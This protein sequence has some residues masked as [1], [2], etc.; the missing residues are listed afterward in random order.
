MSLPLKSISQATPVA[1]GSLIGSSFQRT[2]AKS[3]FF[4]GIGVHSGHPVQMTIRPGSLNNGY[5][6]I[7]K[8]LIHKGFS[9]SDSTIIARWD[10]VV[11]TCMSTKISNTQGVS[12]STVEHV[13]AALYGC[14]VSNACIEINAEEVPILDGSSVEYT[15]A[16]LHAGIETQIHPALYKTITERVSVHGKDGSFIEIFPS[17]RR[18]M[19][20]ELLGSRSLAGQSWSFSFDLDKDS[21]PDLVADARTFG[22][23]GD[24]EK[25]WALGYAKGASLDN[26]VVI[27]DLG[28]IMNPEGLRSVDELVRHKTLDLIGDL[29]LSGLILNGSIVARNPTH[30]LNNKLLRDLL[31]KN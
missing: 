24:A 6:F 4:E 15:T 31:G 22:F 29:A 10:N 25:I 23:Y 13:L 7:R 5:V 27:D 26:A 3:L 20:V 17:D 14:G 12:V 2:L 18:L 28:T 9:R 19:S 21:F 1:D 8:D 30:D 11:D 16:F